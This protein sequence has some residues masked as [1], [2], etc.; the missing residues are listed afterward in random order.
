[1]GRQ[2]FP[3]R[4]VVKQSTGNPEGS[5][6]T[7]AVILRWQNGVRVLRAVCLLQGGIVGNV[8]TDFFF[9]TLSNAE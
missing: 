7:V 6:L 1:M 3:Y 8:V 5:H 2:V 4:Q 9:V